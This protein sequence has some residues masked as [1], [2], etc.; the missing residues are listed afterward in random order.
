MLIMNK[1]GWREAIAIGGVVFIG[2]FLNTNEN[3]TTYA[4]HRL[5]D[6]SIGIV[7]AVAINYT[8]YPPT[9][10]SKIIGEIKNISKNILKYNI[11]SLEILLQED[12]NIG[13][14]EEQI[15]EIEKELEESEKFLELKKK[16][17]KMKGYGDTKHKEMFISFKLEK[18]S[19]EHLKN[20]QNVLQKGIDKEIVELV[21]ADIYKIKADLAAFYFQESEETEIS[22]KK[23]KENLRLEPIIENIKKV[24]AQLKNKEDINNYPTDEV[25]KMLV[26]IYN[27]QETL[28]KFNTIICC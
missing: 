10:D 13:L 1:L 15:Q 3:H 26:F 16:E 4:L 14:L 27:L 18:E 22:S 28:Q 24:K 25:V 11:K 20:I 23:I 12:Q 5:L 2:I 17:E 21:Q 7:V 19:F 8:I 6:T 9:Y